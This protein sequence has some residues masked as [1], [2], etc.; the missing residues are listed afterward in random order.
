MVEADVEVDHQLR[1]PL[2]AGLLSE[3][4]NF[5][6]IQPAGFSVDPPENVLH[7]HDQ[8]HR[9]YPSRFFVHP[10]KNSIDFAQL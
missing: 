1:H 6:Q 3:Q 9:I 5:H 2:Q 8:I 4:G 7:K 10:F